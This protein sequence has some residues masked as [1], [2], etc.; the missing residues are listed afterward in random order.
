MKQT[1]AILSLALFF[2]CIEGSQGIF[3]TLEKEEL[4]NDV[5]NLSNTLTVVDQTIF[6]GEIYL[7]SVQSKRKTVGSDTWSN[8]N[9]SS[10]A[11]GMT[12]IVDVASSDNE[13]I[14]YAIVSNGS[15]NQLYSSAD[16]NTWAQVTTLPAGAIPY[17][18]VEVYNQNAVVTDFVLNYTTSANDGYHAAY[19]STPTDF[20]AFTTPILASTP[21]IQAATDGTDY[22]LVNSS[23]FYFAD[24]SALQNAVAVDKSNLAN[25]TTAPNNFGGII[26]DDNLGSGLWVISTDSGYLFSS[27]NPGTTAFDRINTDRIQDGSDNEVHFGEITYWLDGGTHVFLVAS[28]NGY[29]EVF[30]DGGVTVRSPERSTSNDSYI[31]KIIAVSTVRN[32]EVDAADRVYFGTLSNGLWV[33]E[34]D[35]LDIQ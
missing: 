32:I 5:T 8:W 16:G 15:T 30:D 13:T 7:A 1:L 3:F 17:S 21:I 19:D 6:G 33:A 9:A 31:S 12:R 22:G 35:S 24:G 28:N 34:N 14:I 18:I 20:Q 29:Y 11:S 26:Y 2:S 23:T 27:P 10:I 25:F 4:V